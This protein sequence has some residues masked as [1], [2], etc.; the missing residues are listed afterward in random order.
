MNLSSYNWQG[1][2]CKSR[3]CSASLTWRVKES[4]T[5]ELVLGLRRQMKIEAPSFCPAKYCFCSNKKPFVCF[6]LYI[7]VNSKIKLLFADVL[8]KTCL[9]CISSRKKTCGDESSCFFE[10]YCATTALHLSKL[11]LYTRLKRRK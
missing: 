11:P 5:R 10:D 9:Q 3:Q 1:C 2:S 8:A 6:H 4:E 7:E